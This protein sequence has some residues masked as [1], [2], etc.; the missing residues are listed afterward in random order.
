MDLN[1]KMVLRPAISPLPAQAP[2]ALRSIAPISTASGLPEWPA[3]TR[4]LAE[5]LP[6]G[7]QGPPLLR[8]GGHTVSVAASPQPLRAGQWLLLEVTQA[9]PQPILRLLANASADLSDRLRTLLPARQPMSESL[10][11]LL[12]QAGRDTQGGRLPAESAAALADL[13]AAIPAAMRLGDARSLASAIL[14]SGLFL[15]ARLAGGTELP[16]QDLK[17]L[18]LRLLGTLPRRDR[19]SDPQAGLAPTPATSASPLEAQARTLL[20]PLRS[21]LAEIEWQQWAAGLDESGSGNNPLGRLMEFA[22]PVHLGAGYAVWRLQIELDREAPGSH[23]EARKPGGWR[24]RLALELPRLGALQVWCQAEGER[25]SL[26]LWSRDPTVVAELDRHLPRLEAGLRTAGLAPT[27]LQACE[28]AP[29][30][31]SPGPP[32]SDLVDE[33]A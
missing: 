6:G 27:L 14:N 12:S 17:A 7:N 15:E 5:V 4:L 2:R 24:A 32:R 30:W 22:L 10:G 31:P 8:L 18:L 11:A 13:R 21:A 3:G 33:R 25:L 23:A 16:A 20:G 19:D 29:D 26:R 9:G 28:G 1:N